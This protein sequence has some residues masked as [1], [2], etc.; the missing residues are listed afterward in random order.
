MERAARR[1]PPRAVDRQRRAGLR[2]R[3]AHAHGSEPHNGAVHRRYGDHPHRHGLRGRCDRDV[4]RRGG[5]RRDRHEL[6]ADHSQHPR[7]RGGSRGHRGHEPRH[8]KRNAQRRVHV[9]G[10]AAD[11]DARHPCL[12]QLAG[13]DDRDADRLGLRGRR[14][15]DLR[16]DPRDGR[17]VRLVDAADRDDP[18][19]DGGGRRRRGHEPRSA[20][21]YGDRRILLHGSGGSDRRRRHPR[22]GH[23]RRGHDGDHRWQRLRQRRD[24]HPWRRRSH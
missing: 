14:H 16:R 9:P 10:A 11:G 6:D 21:G 19:A 18:A 13:R 20:D 22:L 2:R 4:Q 17:D 24:R 7:W 15:R 12:G 3:R 23:D 8:A 1:R 5:D